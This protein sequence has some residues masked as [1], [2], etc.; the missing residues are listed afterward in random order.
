MVAL[1][2]R[3]STARYAIGERVLL[4]L[5]A[6]AALF[7]VL[8]LLLPF[9]V[10]RGSGGACR[11]RAPRRCTSPRSGLGFMLYEI[12]MIQKLVGYLGYPSYSLTV[13]LA[14]IL[15]FT[16][17]GALLVEPVLRRTHDGRCRCCSV[18]WRVLTLVLPVR[19]CRR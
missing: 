3:R 7:A 14:S 17:L 8:F 15:V 12:T 1:G 19:A 11:R 13:T 18:R 5:L 16:G 10:I 9:L 2:H 6:I 4:L